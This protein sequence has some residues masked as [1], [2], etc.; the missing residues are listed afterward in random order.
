M[1]TGG[2]I[3]VLTHGNVSMQRNPGGFMTQTK[4]GT[5]RSADRLGC[6]AWL[7]IWVKAAVWACLF[8]GEALFLFSIGGFPFGFPFKA[9]KHGTLK[10]RHA[11]MSF[12]E[13]RETWALCE[14]SGQNSSRFAKLHVLCGS[15]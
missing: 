4:E 12:L 14:G 3:W 8:S 2:T 6:C 13:F 11:C 10:T 15:K 1:F 7:A 5:D 9:T